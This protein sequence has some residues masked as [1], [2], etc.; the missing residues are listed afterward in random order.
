[1]QKLPCSFTKASPQVFF[2]IDV[3]A[4]G[5]LSDFSLNKNEANFMNPA[6]CEL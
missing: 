4:A 3:L 1:M 2:E 5:L 6:D